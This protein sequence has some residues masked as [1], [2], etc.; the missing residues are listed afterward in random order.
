[1]AKNKFLLLI[2]AVLILLAVL[3]IKYLYQSTP[4]I[5][6]PEE[7]VLLWSEK[8]SIPNFYARVLEVKNKEID[9]V[10]TLEIKG[11]KARVKVVVTGETQILRGS[12]DKSEGFPKRVYE[13]GELKDIRQG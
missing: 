2:L 9:T 1:M 6:E 13:A 12:I 4:V 3:G 10:T 7:K 8:E 11:E 5:T